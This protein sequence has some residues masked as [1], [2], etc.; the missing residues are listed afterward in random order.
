MELTLSSSKLKNVTLPFAFYCLPYIISNTYLTYFEQLSE[1]NDFSTDAVELQS[2]LIH[3][4]CLDEKLHNSCIFSNKMLK[5]ELF[6]HTFLYR[7]IPHRKYDLVYMY[8]ESD[9]LSEISFVLMNTLEIDGSLIV[10]MDIPVKRFHVELIYFLSLCFE[11]VFIQEINESNKR[12]L[13]CQNLIQKYSL[14]CVNNITSI[15][16]DNFVPVAFINLIE[17]S[18]ILFGQSTLRQLSQHGR[19]KRYKFMRSSS[20]IENKHEDYE[21]TKCLWERNVI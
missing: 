19:M 3:K 20:W 9:N 1:N 4:Y 21:E 12:L 11:K 15:F 8:S 17:E 13:I 10:K 6:T 7:E 2:Q 16:A 14:P 18:N 5:H